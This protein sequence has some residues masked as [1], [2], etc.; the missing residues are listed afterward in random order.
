M[1]RDAF[2]RLARACECL[3]SRHG[4]MCGA[5]CRP[6]KGAIEKGVDWHRARTSTTHM[7][8]GSN[9]N[10]QAAEIDAVPVLPLPLSPASHDA[11]TLGRPMVAFHSAIAI[12][13][14]SLLASGGRR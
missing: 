5:M 11:S 6:A 10:A 12:A 13:E 1:C 7:W 3:V 14:Y 4:A 2:H 9:A 8:G